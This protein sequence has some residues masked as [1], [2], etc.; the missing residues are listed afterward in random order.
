LLKRS[1]LL[2]LALAFALESAEPEF[3]DESQSGTSG[4]YRSISIDHSGQLQILLA[5][6]KQIQAPK[7]RGQEGFD[8]P[9]LSPDHRTAGWLA[10]YYPDPQNRGMQIARSL[11]LYRGGRI[12][13]KF[14]TEQTFWDWQ[15]QDGGKRVAYSTGPTHG[16]AAECV[17]REVDSGR[18]IARY[19]LHSGASQPAWA[20]TLRQ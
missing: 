8:T 2:G 15:F 19:D 9:L 3:V 16:G 10:I 20:R 13:Q 11:V 17:L 4:E 6:G 7:L 1:L 5:S 12:L 14:A 18:V